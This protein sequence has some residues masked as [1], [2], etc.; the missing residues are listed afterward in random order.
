VITFWFVLACAAAGFLAYAGGRLG[1][2]PLRRSRGGPVAPDGERLAQL[3]DRLPL[4]TIAYDADAR[5]IAW[6]GSAEA[7]FGWT[8][9]D[10][11]G[12]LNPTIPEA[13]RAESDKLRRRILDGETLRGVELERHA[14]DGTV[15]ELSAFSA[16]LDGRI[17]PRGGFLILYDDIR[18]RKSAERSRD[19]AETRF[20]DLV[21]SLP[22]VTYVDHV[23]DQATNIYTSP[24]ITDLLGWE[25]AELL[26][27]GSNSFESLLHP[28]DRARAMAAVERSNA[29]RESFEE[30]YRLRHRDGTYVW[31]RDHSSIIEDTDGQPT[32]RGFLLDI[33]KQKQLEA[34]LLQAE[35]MDALGQFAGGIAHDFNNLLT[36]ISGYAELATGSVHA[37]A[38][39]M[40]CLEG[41]QL[42]A[43]D[44]AS[45][46]SRLLSFSRRDVVEQRLVDL[47]DVVRATAAVLD[48]LVREDVAVHLDLA[49]A[50]PP[51]LADPTQLQ[52]VVLNLGLNARD[53]IGSG[54]AMTIET[55]AAGRF[56]EL[57]VRDTGSGMNE[58]TRARAFEP[59]FTT[60][61]E[62]D[63]TGLGLSIAYGVVASLG[64]SVSIVSAEGSGTTVTAIFPAV[65]TEALAEMAVPTAQP[66]TE[67]SGERLLVV[68]D[69]QVL[70]ELVCAVL[71]E[72]GFI[73]AAAADADEAL[74]IAAR[75]EPF[76]LLLTDVV[77][78]QMSGPHLALALREQ[79]AELPVLY[80]SGYTD[81]VLDAS[82]L[83]EPLTGF[84]RKPFQ[85]AELVAK[86]REL[87]D[88]N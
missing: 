77:M 7:L 9:E 47:N 14:A 5:V 21:E 72:A 79:F 45:L 1:I 18:E 25:P 42:A 24:Q 11:F 39:L 87:L 65:R 66:T 4:A 74:A 50:L 37:D 41:I 6:N 10:A 36:A 3:I 35:K 13:G 83:T 67:R 19:A 17:G 34:Q 20:R 46:T 44:A 69:R 73:V 30:E 2:P 76:D 62:G 82:A 28:D 63:G 27:A 15:L 8:A 80:M 60:K 52:Q 58:A 51:V 81:D 75:S 85:N 59:F 32:G 38:A 55:R 12:K 33:T 84:L 26:A 40:R 56:V 48:R 16:P 68:E 22:L 88:A 53:A 54:G 49:G 70:R 78:P 31:V 86:V 29:T 61:P 57:R 43:A 71:D 64:G 23:D